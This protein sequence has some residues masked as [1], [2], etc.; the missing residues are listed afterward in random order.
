[1]ARLPEGIG[2]ISSEMDGSRGFIEE[3]GSDAGLVNGIVGVEIRERV[4]ADF[5]E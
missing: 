4:G 3:V 2:S 5:L 1:M